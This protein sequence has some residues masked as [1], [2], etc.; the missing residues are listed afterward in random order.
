MSEG[1]RFQAAEVILPCNELS[2]T[3][4]FFAELGFRLDAIF[5]AD[6]PRVAVL[7]GHGLRLRLQ[8]GRG[9]P[10]QLR[11]LYRELPADRADG[12]LIAP[13][14]TRIELTEADPPLVLPLLRPTFTL[15]RAGIDGEWGEGRAGMLYRDL[16]P[17]RQG[18]C[19]IAS[20]IR[21]P[22]GGPVPDS[23]HYHRVQFQMIYCA[24]GWVRVVYEDQGPS[25]VL[26][27]G[28]CVLQPP[29]IRHRV[30]EC[31]DG[32]EVVEIGGPA[33]HET[34]FDHELPLPQATERS[35]RRYSGQEF[36]RH[37]AASARW[38]APANEHY[39]ARD[40]GI[41]AATRGLVSARVLRL[42]RTPAAPLESSALERKHA[43]SSF[44]FVL[45]G[46]LSLV[47]A[48]QEH[49]MTAADAC[50]IPPAQPLTLHTEDAELEFLEVR[51]PSP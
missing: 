21:I 2:P 16:I 12:P 43:S 8:P 19:F 7:S 5:P 26:Q 23:V 40:L 49:R 41:A 18:G 17:D 6:D 9:D 29:Q 39:E 28:D 45:R 11:L 14:G 25:F 27:Q 33:D 1:R 35:D 13:N 46:S 44:W 20:H 42:R 22:N 3:L 15:T 38:E 47:V 24:R 32:L 4:R 31:S 50:V 51:L 36:V 10:G 37:Q 30:L 48:G 34:H